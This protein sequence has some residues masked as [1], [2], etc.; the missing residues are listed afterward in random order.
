MPALALSTLSLNKGDIISPPRAERMHD[1][2]HSRMPRVGSPLGKA[3]SLAVC[4]LP[5]VQRA[6]LIARILVRF[7]PGGGH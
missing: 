2:I 4:P 1:S 7:N 3:I 5:L 6:A